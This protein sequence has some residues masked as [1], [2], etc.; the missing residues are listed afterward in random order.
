MCVC[1]LCEAGTLKHT[2]AER[3]GAFHNVLARSLVGVRPVDLGLRSSVQAVPI[4]SIA[5]D[6][7]SQTEKKS[8]LLIHSMRYIWVLTVC[9]CEFSGPF[10]V[11][12]KR[13]TRFITRPFFPRL[14]RFA[15]S[16]IKRLRFCNNIL[17]LS[18][19]TPEKKLWEKLSGWQHASPTPSAASSPHR[20]SHQHTR[21]HTDLEKTQRSATT[22]RLVAQSFAVS[23]DGVVSSSW[24]VCCVVSQRA[25]LFSLCRTFDLC[26][27]RFHPQQRG[28]WMCHWDSNADQVIIGLIKG[29]L[30]DQWK[31]VTWLTRPDDKQSAVTFDLWTTLRQW[32][33]SHC[34][35]LPLSH[36]P[37]T[38]M[39]RHS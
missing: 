8:W 5:S 30:K 18:M 26:H 36:W 10:Y 17:L 13:F 29:K 6:Y 4:I 14:E 15:A 16:V 22:S 33:C 24:C 19:M 1:G 32:V 39:I 3:G 9:P 34:S 11:I 23:R 21:D 20:A 31:E 38:S 7:Y 37:H 28:V 2:P 27:T 35:V 25:H 12:M